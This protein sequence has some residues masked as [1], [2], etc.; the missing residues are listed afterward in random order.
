MLAGTFPNYKVS[1][2]FMYGFLEDL[3][4]EEF[5]KAINEIVKGT[6]ELYPNANLVALIREKARVKQNKLAAE[7]WLEVLGAVSRVGFYGSP[8]FSDSLIRKAVACV[9]WRS[10]CLSENVGVERSHFLKAYENLAKR[11]AYE[12]LIGKELIGFDGGKLLVKKP[13][14]LGALGKSEKAD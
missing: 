4:D 9:G 2:K 5:I 6:R 14:R 7:A 3:A 10:I 12:E 8:E 11:Q 1:A 13:N